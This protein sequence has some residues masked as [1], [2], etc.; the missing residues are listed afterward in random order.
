VET[1]INGMK[2]GCSI[3][4][5]VENAKDLQYVILDALTTKT[6]NIKLASSI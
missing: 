5:A 4:I 1:N 2:L 3:L 6:K